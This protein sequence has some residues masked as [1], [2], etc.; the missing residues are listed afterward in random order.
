MEEIVANIHMHTRYSDGE[1]S[2]AD[3]AKAALAA[4]IDV[5]IVTDHN[6]L[7]NKMEGYHQDKAR[8]VLMLVGEE[9][10]DRTRN[11][12]KNHLL[13]LGAG[14]ELSLFAAQPQR[15]IDAA[16]EAGG[17]TFLAHPNDQALPAFHETDIT[18]DDWTA[19]DFTGL[20]LWNGFSEIKSVA[21]NHLQAIF[22]VFFPALIA[23]G[24][25]PDTIARWDALNANGRKVVAIGGS[26]AHANRMRLGPLQRTVLPYQ[27]HFRGINNHLL[28]PAPLT[29]TLASDRKM[30]LEALASGNS[31]IGYDLPASTR[32]F[33]FSAQGKTGAASMG[34]TILLEGGVTFQIRI[35]EPADCR[36]IRDGVVIKNWRGREQ[37]THIACDPG[38]YRVECHIEYLGRKRA[39][40]ISNPITVRPED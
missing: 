5:V 14:V 3:I 24:P 40:I 11:P 4:G 36:L 8:R 2:H 12:Q 33:R 32:G 29:S 38:V 28:L 25:H 19:E 7:V 26:D 30:V 39:W 21:H 9:I 34:E 22:Y 15:L 37:C 13:V 35:P 20:E 6:I 18:W 17:L 27:F 1:G 10:H 23:R 16:R 31:F